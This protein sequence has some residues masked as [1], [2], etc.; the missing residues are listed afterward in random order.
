MVTTMNL[1]SKRT[2][3]RHNETIE[4]KNDFIVEKSD[5]N[6]RFYRLV[7]FPKFYDKED[8]GDVL[9]EQIE[10]YLKLIQLKGP[11]HVLVVGI[12]NDSHTADSIGP[13]TIK[14]LH[15]NSH[16]KRLGLPTTGNII[17]ALEP[18]VLGETGIETRRIVEAVTE[19]ISP[20]LVVLIDSFVTKDEKELAHTVVFTDEGIVPGSGLM[21]Q[22]C[23]IDEQSLGIPVLTIG[24]PTAI[25]VH[26]SDKKDDSLAYLLSPSDIDIFVRDIS[27][28]LA[29]C[30][31]AIFLKDERD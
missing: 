7:I 12:G 16:L 13:A 9:V 19:E 23:K 31:N 28:I 2:D 11:Y 29:S 4:K 6:S 15:V 21:G 3:V 17:S 5:E 14:C 25:E 10:D 30:L 1:T 18:G 22:N 27:H 8:F 20:D 26:F 24:I